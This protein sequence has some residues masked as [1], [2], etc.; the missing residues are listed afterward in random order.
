MSKNQKNLSNQVMVAV[1]AGTSL[2]ENLKY[3][4]YYDGD[5][6]NYNQEFKYLGL[7]DDKQIKAV[8]KVIK[9]VYCHYVNGELV[10]SNNEPLDLTREE[11]KEIREMIETTDYYDIRTGNKFF[12][13]EKFYPTSYI[14]ESPSSMRNKRY[15]NLAAIPGHEP[16]MNAEKTATFLDDKTWK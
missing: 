6:R 3:N 1:T 15:F 8:G 13:I 14:K 11:D 12:L 5:K 4:I 10:S 2:A 16:N 9:T 7:Y